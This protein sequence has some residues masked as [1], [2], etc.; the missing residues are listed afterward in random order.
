[1][2]ERRFDI[3]KLDNLDTESKKLWDRLLV[4]IQTGKVFPAFRKDE[5][6]FYH[7][8]GLLFKYDGSSFKRS[9]AYLKYYDDEAEKKYAHATGYHNEHKFIELTGV[10]FV[11]SIDR[12]M[13]ENYNRF[14]G[15]KSLER[16]VLDTFCSKTFTKNENI[17]VLDIEINFNTELDGEKFARKPDMLLLN[18]NTQELMFVE[19]KL[20]SHADIKSDNGQTKKPAVSKQLEIYNNLIA[21][22][23]E[24]QICG[25]YI[26]HISYLNQKF[27]L[28]YKCSK[29]HVVPKTKLLVLD[30][31]GYSMAQKQKVID[32]LGEQVIWLDGDVT[33]ASLDTVW[34][35][36]GIVIV[37]QNN[38][39]H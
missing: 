18:K 31:G 25:E 23:G 33:N 36:A 15:E 13:K 5:I 22:N 37:P 1:M 17:I 24:E 29:L 20:S 39:A 27:M 3:C 12:F 32:T 30:N 28:G 34:R 7:A 19:G 11:E 10:G 26:K 9:L 2:L 21:A 35:E 38:P 4:L 8:G 16:Q 6:H 14:G